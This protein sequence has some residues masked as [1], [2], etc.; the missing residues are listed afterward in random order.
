L[1]TRAWYFK[2]KGGSTAEPLATIISNND[3]D[4]LKSS[5][6][7]VEIVKPG[8][9]LLKN[10]NQSYN[11][12]YQFDLAAFGPRISLDVKVFI[13]GKFYYHLMFS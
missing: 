11:G 1:F 8:T 7:G 4:I 6:S 9:L 10:V 2:R 13:A 12:I 3:P 5:L